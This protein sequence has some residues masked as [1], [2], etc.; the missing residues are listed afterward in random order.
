MMNIDE[1]NNEY[2]EWIYNCVC[3][4]IF[5]DRIS[6]RK[7]FM[8]LYNTEF[9]Y[10]IRNDRNRAADGVDL[11]QR[12]SLDSG[13]DM[14]YLSS[15]L[16]GPCSVLEMIFAL[17]LKCEETIMD[18]PRKGNRTKQWFWGMINSLGLGGMDDSNFDK[19]YV[20]KVVNVFLERRYE[21]N[22]RGGLF[23]IRNCKYDLRDV[24]IWCQL[25]WY[26]DTIT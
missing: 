7:L 23:T 25:C 9:T 26:L 8:Y 15:Y 10:I 3:D 12:F 17:A 1:L 20:A 4:D 2:F 5:S 24:E 19:D 11:R 13:F 14:C 21:P 18:N 22:G 16:D 6:Y